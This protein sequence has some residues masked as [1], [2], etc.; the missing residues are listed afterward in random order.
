MRV[1]GLFAQAAWLVSPYDQARADEL[2]T[3]AL[4]A[5]DYARANGVDT[6][7][8]GPMLYAAGELYR[9]T[10]QS[11]FKTLFESAWGD[12]GQMRGYYEWPGYYK[13]TSDQPIAYSHVL[14]YIQADDADPAIV[15]TIKKQLA[16]HGAHAM[17]NVEENHAHRH[18]RAT[19][20]VPNW[21]RATGV[22]E[23]VMGLYPQF[24]LDTASAEEKQKYINAISI[25]ADYV[26]GANPMGQVWITGLGSRH[27][28]DILHLDSLTFRADGQG[29]LPGIP[30]YGPVDGLP[31][32]SY[33]DYGRN[34]FYPEFDE[35]PLLRRYGDLNVFVSNNEFEISL[36]AVQT[37][38]MAF[39]WQE[40]QSQDS[41]LNTMSW[42][43]TQESRHISPS[44]SSTDLVL[45]DGDITQ[46]A[47][48]S[49]T[50]TGS[51]P[52]GDVS[53]E[54]V[55]IQSCVKTAGN[56]L[57][58]TW[59]SKAGNAY[60]VVGKDNLQDGEWTELSGPIAAESNVTSWRLEEMGEQSM[61]FF[62]VRKI[63]P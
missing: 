39:L 49:E 25:S 22:G 63:N 20:E 48:S 46:V 19:Q 29:Q 61:L 2:Q 26:L 58:L 37:Q 62:A 16:T 53:G 11:E 43:G 13:W 10:G 50:E 55:Q 40:N 54:S 41:S 17:E 42:S 14:A 8:R 4:N 35:H 24:L 7:I 47:D 27:P 23:Y 44:S 6:S 18:G 51:E 45:T 38:L 57:E 33:Y 3:C 12:G 59:D 31:G 34:V 9:L 5:Y 36:Q 52:A 28:Q 30:V 15:D 56:G 60:Q 32:W 1:A 21:G